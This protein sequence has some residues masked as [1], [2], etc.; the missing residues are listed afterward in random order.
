MGGV[1][2]IPVAG[3]SLGHGCGS[4]TMSPARIPGSPARRD[5][6]P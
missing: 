1:H 4:L 5:G 2:E 6:V 3:R